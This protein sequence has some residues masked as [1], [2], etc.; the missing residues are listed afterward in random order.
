MDEVKE[1]CADIMKM[2]KELLQENKEN[3]EKIKNIKEENQQLRRDLEKLK[4]RLEEMENKLESKDKETTKNNIVIRGIKIGQPD[5]NKQIEQLIKEKLKLDIKITNVQNISLRENKQL[6]IATVAN[7]TDK[8]AILR[9]KRQL[10]GTHIFIDEDLSKNERKIQ[11]IIRDRANMERK[12]GNRIK[13]G[14]KKLW[15]N[16]AL[17]RWRNEGEKLERNEHTSASPNPKN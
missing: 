1:M 14:Y 13:M 3:R 10:K 12:Q 7:L 9:E 8:K 6:T 16:G 15:I 2:V 17:W 4:G 11:K 5:A